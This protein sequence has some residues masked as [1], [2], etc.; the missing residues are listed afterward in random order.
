M[1]LSKVDIADVGF[2]LLAH[3][4]G[5]CWATY[6]GIQYLSGPLVR[7]FT[8]QVDEWRDAT[9]TPRSQ[10]HVLR[11]PRPPPVVPAC[12]PG[13]LL[14]RFDGATRQGVGGSVGFVGFTCDCT[15]TCAYSTFYEGLSDPFL[16]ELLSLRDAMIWSLHNGHPSVCF[17]GD[18]QL[19][20][21]RGGAGA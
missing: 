5:R 21:R 20:I 1:Q 12:T 18:S 7:Q 4:E 10:P 8:K 16:L 9:A 19:V 6:D 13:G 11:H 15:L 3:M 2:Y 17:C 14:I